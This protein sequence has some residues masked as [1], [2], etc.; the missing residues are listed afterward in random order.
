M[1]LDKAMHERSTLKIGVAQTQA[2]DDKLDAGFEKHRKMIEAARREDIEVLLFPELSLSGHGIGPGFLEMALS[3]DD[4]RILELAGLAGDMVAVFGLIEDGVAAQFYNS[5]VAVQGG[6]V[7]FVHRKINLATYGKLEEGKHFAAG[8]Y[9][10][11][12]EL[13]SPWK[14]SV[15]V[16][17][18][19]W[20]PALVNLAALHGATLLLAPISS[21]I[22]AVGAEFDNPS[23]WATC[24]RFYSMI[25]GLPLVMANRVGREGEFEFWGGSC[26]LDPFGHV[27]AQADGENESLISATL[28]YQ[29]LRRARYLL[30]TVRDSNL[31][32]VLRESER[33]YQI[34]GV[35]DSVRDLP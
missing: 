31:D 18:D 32:L 21:A 26:I 28:N 33:L 23:G 35:P 7:F 9:V 19:L 22:G 6:R 5:V 34:I 27:L 4:P 25:Y 1:A 10:E 24:L 12:F 13:G 20:N 29:D 15:L 30:P 11:T 3:R 8:R 14:A 17:N 16:C 2:L